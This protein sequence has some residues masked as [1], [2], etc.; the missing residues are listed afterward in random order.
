MSFSLNDAV[1]QLIISCNEFDFRLTC[2]LFRS[3]LTALRISLVRTHVASTHGL[4]IGPCG[5]HDT[6]VPPS[7]R[8]Q[9]DQVFFI[10][11]T[12]QR[13][14]TVVILAPSCNLD[15]YINYCYNQLTHTHSHTR[16][17]THSFVCSFYIFPFYCRGVQFSVPPSVSVSLSRSFSLTLSLS[18]F[19]SS[20]FLCVRREQLTTDFNASVCMCAFTYMQTCV[21]VCVHTWN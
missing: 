1:L 7:P 17:L 3:P 21:C 14:N 19:F 18:F 8:Q 13:S 20:S 5:V 12:W 15:V 10:M 2:R 16:T 9:R 4:L 11:S 6:D